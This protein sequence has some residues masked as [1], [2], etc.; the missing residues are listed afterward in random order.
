MVGVDGVKPTYYLGVLS[1]LLIAAIAAFFARG[2][3]TTERRLAWGM[4][5]SL[6]VSML[7]VCAFP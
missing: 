4:S 1:S 6:G 7:L 3:N 2:Y 5:L